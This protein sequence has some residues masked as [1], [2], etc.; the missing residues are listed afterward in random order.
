[1]EDHFFQFDDLPKEELKEMIFQVSGLN[2][3]AGP[4]AA[5]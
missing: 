4:Q 3:P 1:L 5:Q 2:Y